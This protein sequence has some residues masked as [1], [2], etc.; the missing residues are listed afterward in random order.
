MPLFEP[1]ILPGFFRNGSRYQ[2]K[3][4]WYD[5]SLVRFVGDVIQPWLGW[6]EILDENGVAVAL[7]G[8]PRTIKGWRGNDGR[9]LLA[10]G[11][12]E[13]LYVYTTDGMLYDITPAGFTAGA[14]DTEFF[15]GA[16]NPTGAY[17]LGPYGASRYGVADPLQQDVV[18]A[19]CWHLDTFGDYLVGCAYPSD[20]NLYYWPND[21]LQ[22]AQPMAGAPNNCRGIVVTGERFVLALGAGGDARKVEWPSQESLTDWTPTAINTAGGFTLDGPGDIVAGRRGEGETLVWTTDELFSIRYVG[23]SLIYG[24]RRVG[25][26]CGLIAPGAVVARGNHA[27]WMGDRGFFTY[28]GSVQ[29]IPCDVLDYV[30]SD[31]NYD[32]RA[33]VV[34]T[35]EARWGEYRWH[36][37]SSGSSENDRYVSWN[38]EANHWTFGT[39]ARSAAEDSGAL[40]YPVAAT[41]SGR[42][43][44][45]NRGLER[46]DEDGARL[47]PFVESGPVE[48][49]DGD[50]ILHV[51]GLVPNE[52]VLNSASYTLYG[53]S[54]S[55][56]EETERGTFGTGAE[57]D[58][59]FSARAIRV[60][61]QQANDLDWRAGM[62]R[63]LVT[64]AGRRAARRPSVRS[65]LHN[66]M[67]DHGGTYSYL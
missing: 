22:I 3:N 29:R 25:S 58:L 32:Q 1:K 62:P 41:A 64:T 39:L 18:P 46:Q 42:L 55:E 45:H 37:P 24:R 6:E 26:K 5:G 49:S 43:F 54:G 7:T 36:Y 16:G 51:S 20:G 2:S 30:F 8:V 61:I 12:N 14:V 34:A 53:A 10:V 28:N 27:V 56:E 57:V 63:L 9:T 50:E 4:R 17:G 67:T 59:R 40:T 23:G 13:K 21:V 65:G 44:E 31:F 15:D 35:T 48:L 52:K 60:R 38:R 11:T 33:K 47:L 19:T 66:G